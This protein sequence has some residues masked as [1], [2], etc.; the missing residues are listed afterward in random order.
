MIENKIIKRVIMKN[1]KRIFCKS[2]AQNP[3]I[4]I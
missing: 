4:Q 3:L 2:A 1:K